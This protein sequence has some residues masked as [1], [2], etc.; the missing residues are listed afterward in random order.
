LDLGQS[1]VYMA[2][3][4]RAQFITGPT[5]NRR[6]QLDPGKL[7]DAAVRPQAGAF[8]EGVLGFRQSKDYYPA[9]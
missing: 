6:E 1:I 4:A 7:G 2:H 8:Q 9:A 5:V 3:S